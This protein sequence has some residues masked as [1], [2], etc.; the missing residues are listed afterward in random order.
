MLRKMPILESAACA[1][2]STLLLFGIGVLRT[3]T[4]VL[5]A[6]IAYAVVGGLLVAIATAGRRPTKQ[7]SRPRRVLAAKKPAAA[8][9]HEV[10]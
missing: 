3:W 5:V 4:S 10:H 8:E 7:P 9:Q 2:A 6:L 1:F